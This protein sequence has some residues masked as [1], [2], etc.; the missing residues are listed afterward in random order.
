MSARAEIR[1]VP[2]FPKRTEPGRSRASC[3][4]LCHARKGRGGDRRAF[5]LFHHPL[6]RPR[7]GTQQGSNSNTPVWGI[8]N[9]PAESGVCLRARG[10]K[11]W[12]RRRHATPLSLPFPILLHHQATTHCS[13]ISS[14]RLQRPSATT[15]APTSRT[16]TTLFYYSKQSSTE[17][18][19]CTVYFY[20]GRRRN[21]AVDTIL[22]LDT[23]DDCE[24][25][26]LKKI[27]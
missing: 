26:F 8:H 15:A 19:H 3:C 10:R 9:I 4:C 22:Y 12:G 23:D 27:F 25:D 16:P 1:C 13:S 20:T 7:S 11:G 2:P 14:R 18:V 17:R 5:W 6:A 21:H 24:K